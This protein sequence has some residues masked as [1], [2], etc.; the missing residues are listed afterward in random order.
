MLALR[1]LVQVAQRTPAAMARRAGLSH[2]ELQVL[3]LVSEGATSPAELSRAVGVTS[4]AM[5]GIV[6]RLESRGHASRAP[7][8]QDGRRTVI[9]ISESGRA[10]ALTH[11]A[12]MLTELT[13]VDA[14]MTAAER[15]VVVGFLKAATRAIRQVE[16]P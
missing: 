3:E 5:S 7:H 11:L 6:D 12:P 9:E 2:S 14:A 4:A 13:A 1:E 15:E 16:G 8:P 10:E